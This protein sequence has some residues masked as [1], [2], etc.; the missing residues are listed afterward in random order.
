TACRHETP[1]DCGEGGTAFLRIA[2]TAGDVE[3]ANSS[4]LGFVDQTEVDA[5]TRQHRIALTGGG[6]HRDRDAV[7][8]IRGDWNRDFAGAQVDHFDIATCRVDG[9]RIDR[10]LGDFQIVE[11][12]I[13]H[14]DRVLHEDRVADAI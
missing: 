2:V 10:R 13:G 7:G 14:H 1:A 3:V 11:T 8:A 12:S 9:Q 4:G 5:G 6:N